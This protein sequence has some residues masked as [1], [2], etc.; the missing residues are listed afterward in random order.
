MWSHLLETMSSMASMWMIMEDFKAIWRLGEH[1]VHN[2]P[3]QSST[4]DFNGA[5][6]DA[7]LT[8][9]DPI[10]SFFTWDNKRQDDEN[11]MSRID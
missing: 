7:N 9:M 2:P 8:E 1:R 11:S 6:N 3:S 5:L 10:G 4:N